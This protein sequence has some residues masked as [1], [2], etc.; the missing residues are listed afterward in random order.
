M[1][2]Y[3]IIEIQVNDPGPY[4]EY[5]RRVPAIVERYGGRYLARGGTVTP[6]FGDWHPQRL[7]VIEFPSLDHLQRWQSSPEYQ[8]LAPLRERSTITRAIAIEGCSMDA[9]HAPKPL[10][11][12]EAAR[13][14]ITIQRV[15][16]LSLNS[17]PALQTTFC[18]GWVLRFA[19]GYTRRANS[20]V[21]L[22]PTQGDVAAKILACEEVYRDRGLPVIF[23]LTAES[24][25]AELD[26]LLAVQ[27]YLAEARTSVQLMDLGQCADAPMDVCLTPAETEEW[28]AAFCRMSALGVHQQA[29]HRQL[30]DAIVPDKC[31]AAVSADGHVVGCGLGVV[32]E[33][34]LG[35]FDIVIDA[36]W[37]RQGYGER[38][39][40]SLLAWGEK[41]QAHTAYLQ[42]MLN[43]EPALR[44]YA[45]LGFREWYQY[46]YRVKR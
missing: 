37:R 11:Q 30:L 45:K 4:A 13:G 25:P 6:I 5:V 24:Y 35:L 8:A 9:C 31:F 28:Q 3:M 36:G 1:P 29:T 14:G 46:W 7:I 26:A 44:L 23:K 40:R 12:R 20:I 34:F 38:L 27:G 15:E 17:W 43:N 2:V 10:R 41:Q 33:G 21:P 32:Q 19:G 39:V 22:Y 18:D 16:E 42:V